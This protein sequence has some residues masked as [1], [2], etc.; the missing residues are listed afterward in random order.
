MPPRL[1]APALPSR[2]LQDGLCLC[3]AA[4][5][6]MAMAAYW[7]SVDGTA[8]LHQWIQVGSPLPKPNAAQRGLCAV[9]CLPI[10]LVALLALDCVRRVIG[11]PGVDLTLDAKGLLIRKAGRA[12]VCLGALKVVLNT[13]VP[14]IVTLPNP[15]GERML[16]VSVGSVECLA[17]VMGCLLVQIAGTFVSAQRLTDELGEFV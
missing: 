3:L 2:M 5:M 11:S 13:V 10:L 1:P 14:L 8:L 4:A 7:W 16:V 9:A 6:P 12:L 15:P 17:L